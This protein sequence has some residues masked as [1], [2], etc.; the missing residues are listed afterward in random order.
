MTAA[1]EPCSPS[2]C[3]LAVGLPLAREEFLR[4]LDPAWDGDFARHVRHG[5]RMPG[6]ADEWYW[7]F[8]YAPTA[9][10][11][12]RV[13]DRVERL[14]V[15][16]VRSAGLTDLP[17][18]LRAYRVVTVLGH[19]K[20]VRLVPEDVPAPHAMLQALAAAKNPVQ[21]QFARAVFLRAPELFAQSVDVGAPERLLNALNGI[22]ADAHRAYRLSGSP[23]G[24]QPDTDGPPLEEVRQRLT[25]PALEAAF[26]DCL[27]AGRC[28]ELADGMHTVREFVDAVPAEFGGVLDL[29]VCNSVI[30]GAAVKRARGGCQVA[31][32]RYPAN[33]MYRMSLYRLVVECLRDRAQPYSEAMAFVHQYSQTRR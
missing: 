13:C 2:D 6:A 32:N 7:T 8:V 11:V 20:F 27:R 9:R 12:E 29:S 14:G 15:R 17:P 28:I 23:A 21:R 5:N 18:L 3:A 4:Q 31:M 10:Q 22:I 19:W 26:P 24:V 30:V 1:L 16:V 25:R 33:I